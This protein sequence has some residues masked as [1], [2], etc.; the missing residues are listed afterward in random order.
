MNQ[1]L[2]RCVYGMGNQHHVDY[3]ADLAGMDSTEINV[4]QMLHE[5]RDDQFIMDTLG[6]DKNAF[7]PVEHCVRMKLYLAIMRCVDRCMDIDGK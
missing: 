6:M 5:K 2:K 7:Q 4:F 1:V 3:L